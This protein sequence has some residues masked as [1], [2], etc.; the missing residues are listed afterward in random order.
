MEEDCVGLVAQSLGET[1]KNGQSEPLKTEFLSHLKNHFRLCYKRVY[2][3]YCYAHFNPAHVV[4]F[5]RL[6]H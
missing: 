5:D 6:I 1:A 3:N 2:N 4:Y